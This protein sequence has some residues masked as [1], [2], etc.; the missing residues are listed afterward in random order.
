MID[1]N[2][3]LPE[4]YQGDDVRFRAALDLPGALAA[5]EALRACLTQLE[6]EQANRAK[7]IASPANMAIWDAAAAALMLWRGFLADAEREVEQLVA[8]LD[9]PAEG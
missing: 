2:Q 5:V 9:R 6:G 3:Y 7:M 1:V 8:L 4:H